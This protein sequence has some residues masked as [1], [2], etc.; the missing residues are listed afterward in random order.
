[1]PSYVGDFLTS[2]GGGFWQRGDFQTDYLSAMND[3]VW[4]TTQAQWTY[5]GVVNGDGAISSAINTE[6]T[7]LGYV[8]GDGYISSDSE[9]QVAIVISGDVAGAGYLSSTI[10]NEVVIKVS[11]YVAGTAELG[12]KINKGKLSAIN[13]SLVAEN[14]PYNPGD[15]PIAAIEYVGFSPNKII[16]LTDRHDEVFEN[17]RDYDLIESLSYNE[18]S[19]LYPIEHYPYSNSYNDKLSYLVTQF[20]SD[21][22]KG[23]PLFYQYEPMFNVASDV[24]GVVNI[25]I[26]KNNET[27]LRPSEYKI[28]Y[29]YDLLPT[30]SRY[31]DTSWGE[32][33]SAKTHRIRV[34]LPYEAHNKDIFYTI[35]YNKYVNNL[36]SYQK[37]IVELRPIYDSSDYTIASSGLVVN[38]SGRIQ[39][40]GTPLHIIKDPYT[41]IE[42]L[43]LIAIKG[44][45][46]YLSDRVAQWKL[47]LNQGA[48]MVASGFY[49]GS[50]EKFYNLE[51]YYYS[52]QYIPINN[53]RPRLVDNNILKI[54]EA[55]I[56]VDESTFT[57][58]NYTVP[59]YDKTNLFLLDDA[60]KFAVDV[61]GVTR[62]DIKIRSIDR[63]KGFIELNKDLDPTDEIEVSYF[64]DNSGWVLL[65]N[66][67]LNP[68]VDDSSS[69]YHISGYSNGLGIALKPW[70]GTSGT[71]Y[72][73]IYDVSQEESSRTA[74]SIVQVPNE[75]LTGTAWTSDFYTICELDVNKLTTDMVELTDARRPA[76][77][78]DKFEQLETWLKDLY[79]SDSHEMDWYTDRGNYDG[80][81]LPHG[82]TVLIHVP[83]EKLEEEKQKWIDH[84]T[85]TLGDPNQGEIKGTEEFK[86][87]LD[88]VIRRYVSAG[89]NYL[90]L[91]TVSGIFK[92]QIMEL[93]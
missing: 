73:Y 70:D 16:S 38:P 82:G 85:D 92:G 53:V 7:I 30:S 9:F 69:A 15:F 88:Q 56:Y 31:S 46:G 23:K 42:P 17:S 33:S 52:G 89:T 10:F 34:L 63:V 77:G 78:I 32:I 13:P 20:N 28:Q 2:Q 27:K 51:D 6:F 75:D 64:L 39:D 83:N 67:E 91:P 49:T 21:A 45:N 76:G 81:P 84:Y 14:T 50:T 65:E 4:K 59:V 40:T 90:I 22:Q 54:K 48:F 62:E 86:F 58:P 55:P 72:P 36:K 19:G 57:Y 44:E 24:S 26:Y 1:M 29:S 60:G 25:N 80:I 74:Y 66:L 87:Y 37:E 47:R 18:E 35:E 68:K 12:Y 43:G 79:G 3:G 5:S 93:V 8:A 11:G 61:N 71:Y 41:K